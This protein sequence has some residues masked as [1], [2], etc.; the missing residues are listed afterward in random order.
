MLTSIAVNFKNVHQRITEILPFD[1]NHDFSI[2]LKCGSQT[3]I[4]AKFKSMFD[5]QSTC[6]PFLV[7]NWTQTMLTYKEISAFKCNFP[8]I[9]F[10]DMKSLYYENEFI[11]LALGFRHS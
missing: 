2:L 8:K 6:P 1:L 9:D 10:F 5:I 4:A 7:V 11:L 3:V